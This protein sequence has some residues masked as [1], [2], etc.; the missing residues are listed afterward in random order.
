MVFSN[1]ML[2]ANN[3]SRDED[4]KNSLI[5]LLDLKWE[6]AEVE[7]NNN[8]QLVEARYNPFID[9]IEI[10]QDDKIFELAKSNNRKIK[11]TDTNITYQA[12]SYY[13]S[14][15]KIYSSYFIVNNQADD[16]TVL[17]R[18][19]IEFNESYQKTDLKYPS[20][21]R[22]KEK[23]NKRN[24]YYFIDDNNRL[25]LLTTNRRDIKKM[26]PENAKS[27]INFITANKLTSDTEKDMTTLAAYIYSLKRENI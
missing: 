16:I 5:Q 12:K 17:K 2:A 24:F 6:K 11:F 26:F 4:K 20:V 9:A 14:D 15:N 3:P 21:V 13:G 10:K 19:W 23:Y 1:N 7:F 8:Y 25:F 22:N 18:E 27:I